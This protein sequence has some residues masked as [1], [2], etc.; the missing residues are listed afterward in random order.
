MSQEVLSALVL[1]GPDVDVDRRGLLSAPRNM[2]DLDELCWTWGAEVGLRVES[3]QARSDAELAARLR[4]V[5][6]F[7][8]VILHAGP[9]AYSSQELA[10]T[11]AEVAIPVVEVD[12]RDSSRAGAPASLLSP[13]CVRTVHGRGA[14]GFRWALH[15]LVHREVWPVRTIAYGDHRDQVGDLRIPSTPPPHPVSVLVHGGFWLQPW[16]RDLMEAIAVD[17][18]WNGVATWNVEYRRVGGDGGW[19]ATADDVES[20]I[21]HLGTL[22]ERFPLD[23][24]RTTVVGHSAG[25]QLAVIATSR[26]VGGRGPVRPERLVSLAGLLDLEAAA[27]LRLGGGAVEQFALASGTIREDTL[28]LHRLPIATPQVIVHGDADELVP[29]DQST[30]YVEAARRSGDRVDHVVLP[31]EDHFDLIDPR[32]PAWEQVRSFLTED[33]AV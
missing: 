12:V 21:A 31:G 22:A 26:A 33:V 29:A 19:P 11:L 18:A 3:E 4:E 6:G 1:H 17:L 13:A 15:H 7:D 8:G 10:A 16:E 9:A 28:P 14:D 30:A 32:R 2:R 5:E 27:T 23:L 24:K 20:A 25:A